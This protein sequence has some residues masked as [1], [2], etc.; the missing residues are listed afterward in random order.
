MVKIAPSIL[1]ADFGCL[2]DE[3]IKLEK[4]KADLIH[5]D[6]M[7]GHFVPN[8][9]FGPMI[10]ENLKKYS[11]LLFD[12]HLMVNNPTKFIPWYAK[13]G[14]DIITFHLEASDNP[15]EDINLIK[16]YGIK[17]GI[18]IKPNTE[19]SAILPFIDDIDLILIMSVEP[20][21]GGQKFDNN[22]LSRIDYLR[23]SIKNKNIIIEV[24]G[25]INNETAKLCRDAN[26]DILVAGTAVF[27]SDNY[28]KSIKELKGET[29]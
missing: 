27:K 11:N 22:A 2:R 13:A 7:D 4:A 17:A 8:I 12:V 1:A 26:V 20:G 5:F 23:K 25:G 14:A 3:I 24:D 15:I 29:L 28:E 21:F 16:Q 18:S 19:I 6:V 9:T 10:L